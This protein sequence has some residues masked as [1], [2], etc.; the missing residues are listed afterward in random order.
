MYAGL[1][2]TLHSVQCFVGQRQGLPE[3][4]LAPAIWQLCTVGKAC[5]AAC[6]WLWVCF[7]ERHAAAFNGRLA[8]LTISSG[9][10]SST[11]GLPQQHDA[12]VPC[13]LP[14]P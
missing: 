7:S 13:R 6:H 11:Q 9:S 4:P 3:V 10:V 2:Q 8:S 1:S 5:H 12:A 14:S